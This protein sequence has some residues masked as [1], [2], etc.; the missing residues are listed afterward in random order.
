M[1]PLGLI[2]TVSNQKQKFKEN[3][4]TLIRVLFF[5]SNGC[6][7]C[8]NDKLSIVPFSDIYLIFD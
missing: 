7:M 2:R 6:V 8:V 5:L 3:N 1:K 4:D